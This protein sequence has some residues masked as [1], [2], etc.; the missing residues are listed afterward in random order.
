VATSLPG[1]R[2]DRLANKTDLDLGFERLLGAVAPREAPQPAVYD[3]ELTLLQ[4]ARLAWPVVEPAR[5]FVENWHHAA[6]C[7]HLEACSRLEIKQ[8]IITVPPRHTKSL[9]VSVFW[10]SWEWTF[11]PGIR[12]I[13][14]SYSHALSIRDSSK[15]R[16]VIESAWYQR[17]WGRVF[18]LASDQNTKIK[19]ENDQ[20]GFRLA[21]STEGLSTGEGGD[22][23]VADDPHNIKKKESDADRESV[24]TWWDEV[25]STRFNHPE[26]HAKVIVMQRS[27]DADLVGH[28]L[29]ENAAEY[30]HL[31]LSSE[32]SA[33]RSKVTVQGFQDPRTKE[34][35]LLWPA[36]FTA[37]VLAALK[38][39]LGPS[40]YSAQFLQDPVAPGGGIFKEVWLRYWRHAPPAPGEP[41][42]DDWVLFTIEVE[43]W[44]QSWD[45]AFKGEE[46]SDF[47]V[48]EAW[49]KVQA[50]VFLVDETRG[51]L[52]FPETQRALLEFTAKHPRATTKAIEDKANGPAVI[53]SLRRKVPG[54]VP[55]DNKGTNLLSRAHSVS[56]YFA[57]GN[58]YIPDPNMPGYEW[59]LDWI[60]EL[61]R[62]DKAPHDDRV[63]SAVQAILILLGA[64]DIR[65]ALARAMAEAEAEGPSETHKVVD[66]KY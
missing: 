43:H 64:I 57:S 40:A 47:V 29:Q 34:G 66:R 41:S 65:E 17:R 54:L 44:M 48:G 23:L 55:I 56:P 59:V 39:T 6:I 62:F 20:A 52:S 33:K 53:Q 37:R 9:L 15:T 38:K 3:P 50:D 25:F 12:W 18:Q 5:P 61:T 60:I 13:F 58:V 31:N 7:D 4:Y 2:Y 26:L 14:S 42:V 35:E 45:M 22:R 32:Y 24:T 16:R 30:E 10:P 46:D 49:A 51:Q 28:V 8:L 27:H 21:T 11:A 19:F 1:R 63:A 36:R